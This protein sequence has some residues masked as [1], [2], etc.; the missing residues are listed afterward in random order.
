MMAGKLVLSVVTSLLLVGT[1]IAQ[2]TLDP[3]SVATA[4]TFATQSRGD[5]VIGLNPANLGYED[6]PRFQLSYGL[7]PLIPFPA[8]QLSND[9]I[10]PSWFNRQFLNRGLLDAKAV[11]KLLAVFPKQGW[12]INP[13]VQMQ[14][15]G[16]SFG[17]YAVSIAPEIQGGI[18]IPKPLLQLVFDG[19]RFNKPVDLSAFRSEAQ[20]VIPVTFAYGYELD[21]ASLN[22]YVKRSYLGMG[23][24]VL[25]GA[26]YAKT[27]NVRGE[28]VSTPS[29]FSV[30][31]EGELKSAVGGVGLAFDVGLATDV[32]DHIKANIA[33][34]NLL[35]F[36]HWSGA[37]AYQAE[38]KFAAD[39]TAQQLEEI[40]DYSEAQQDSMMESFMQI[41]T[42][43]SISGFTTAYP[44]YLLVGF[45][46]EQPV[47]GVNFYVNYRQSFRT[48]YDSRTT[49]RLSLAVDLNSKRRL[50]LRTG[51]AIGGAEKFQWGVGFGLR[52]THYR[53]D[54]GFS[55]TRGMFN[56]ARGFALSLEQKIIF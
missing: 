23:I 21:F 46:V 51:F 36:I 12:G 44:A 14:L 10:S 2:T 29:S 55:Q 33:L 27:G 35:G 15:I 54:L 13:Q 25:G 56:Y 9:A 41:D 31:G 39:I 53:L 49:P 47:R 5:D 42:V 6:N 22:Y 43:Y 52:F 19:I 50:L 11:D 17:S 7:L 30:A 16:I 37:N 24:K 4:G 34:N 26:A 18:T 28:I 8:F 38:F 32:S 3:V 40:S 20:A 1:G 45:Q 48:S